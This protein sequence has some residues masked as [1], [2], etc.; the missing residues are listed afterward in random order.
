MI[1]MFPLFSLQTS[2]GSRYTPRYSSTSDSLSDR[3]SST[4][5]DRPSSYSSYSRSLTTGEKDYKKVGPLKINSVTLMLLVANMANTLAHGT[6]MR[7]LN[8]SY[9]MNSNMTGFR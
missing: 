4:R 7:V 9:P 8:E 2:S 5:A 1:L 3:Y 6:H